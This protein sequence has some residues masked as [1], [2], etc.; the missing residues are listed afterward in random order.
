L[1]KKTLQISFLSFAGSL[2][3]FLCQL[4]IA[5]YFGATSSFDLFVVASTYPLFLTG[6]IAITLN[7]Y[8]IPELA[9]RKNIKIQSKF[10]FLIFLSFIAFFIITVI[11][12]YFIAPFQLL[13]FGA[14]ENSEYINIARIY[15]VCAAL[16]PI[17][18]LFQSVHI[19]KNNIIYVTKAHLIPILMSLSFLLVF[20]NSDGII[21]LAYSL[22]TGTILN[23]FFLARSCLFDM[24]P[25]RIKLKDYSVLKLFFKR[26]T[27]IVL[28]ILCYIVFQSS[29]VYWCKFL[30]TSSLSYVSY[31][32][33]F[34]VAFTA[35][36]MST[37][38]QLFLP[39]LSN[40]INS[41]KK[42]DALMSIIKIFR[43][44]ITLIIF[45]SIFFYIYSEEIISAL[46]QR[47]L[48]DELATKNVAKLISISIFSSIFYVGSTLL[49]RFLL[50]EYKYK[51]TAASGIFIAVTYFV[52][53][54]LLT[55]N[56]GLI[57]IPIAYS[58]SWGFY[59]IKLLSHVFR[60]KWKLIF[61]T[62][63][64]VFLRNILFNSF[65]FLL[66]GFIIKNICG[67][68]IG[69]SGFGIIYLTIIFIVMSVIYL[70]LII[71]IFP[72]EDLT[73]LYKKY[74]HG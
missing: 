14:S 52:M 38:I 63:N 35:L 34:L 70:L 31:M 47:G 61:N 67:E 19:V 40:Q 46:L 1:I 27:L 48:F 3:G 69:T 45:Q 8:L 58:I 54:G 7:H 44:S 72:L 9:K 15:W 29:D 26:M 64:F 53:S 49:L 5:K 11:F 56:L 71:K 74:F 28:S 4:F 25:Y 36:N 10:Y 42:N 68:I 66:I 30:P 21:I 62:Y 17:L 43:V 16:N 59:F 20:K 39:Y 41:G 51:I 37:P 50:A 23:I 33:R 13:Y 57:G 65:L 55:K 12:G 24:T 73:Y 22:L 2:L 60:S 6:L 18:G 32:Q